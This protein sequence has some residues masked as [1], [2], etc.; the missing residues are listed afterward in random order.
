MVHNAAILCIQENKFKE[1]KVNKSTVIF[2]N[3]IV[4][5]IGKLMK[6]SVTLSFG[7]IGDMKTHCKYIKDIFVKNSRE[8]K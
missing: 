2:K 4:K 1:F 3:I 7:D 6:A 8:L 5:L